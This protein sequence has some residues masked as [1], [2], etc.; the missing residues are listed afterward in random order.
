[1]TFGKDTN[2][3][4]KQNSNNNNNNN[5]HEMLHSAGFSS[6]CNT[7]AGRGSHLPTRQAPSRGPEI[8][9][10]GHFLQC[11]DSGIFVFVLLCDSS[12]ISNTERR[13]KK[14]PNSEHCKKS[15]LLD[16]GSARRCL[17]GR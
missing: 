15:S 11:S 4:T 1:M 14:T 8:E 10:R 2:Q 3:N 16:F 5:N 9:K 17:P 7:P 6:M 12:L 13:M